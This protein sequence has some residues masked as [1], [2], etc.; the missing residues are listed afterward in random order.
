MRTRIHAGEVRC[1]DRTPAITSWTSSSSETFYLR[2]EFVVAKSR[3]D[4]YLL[5][6][7]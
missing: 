7:S 2:G 4:H 1:R 3:L 6:T 5:L